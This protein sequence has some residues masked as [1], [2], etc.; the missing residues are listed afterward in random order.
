[1]R[2]WAFS[3]SSSSFSPV[4]SLLTTCLWKLKSILAYFLYHLHPSLKFLS[5]LFFFT[6]EC[7]NLFRWNIAE[8]FLAPFRGAPVQFVILEC[9][10]DCL[11]WAG[12]LH[13]DSALLNLLFKYW[14][15]LFVR[16]IV[17]VRF[18][19]FCGS[20]CECPGSSIPSCKYYS[21]NLFEQ[22]GGVLRFPLVRR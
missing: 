6:A 7:Q 5:P 1:M 22:G 18:R 11:V 21:R 9:D 12:P 3:L 19:E 14:N 10:A 8:G 16:I 15:T 20:F 2:K 17:D 4:S 13:R